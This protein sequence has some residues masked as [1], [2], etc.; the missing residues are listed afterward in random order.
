MR[1]KFYY[2]HSG[3]TYSPTSVLLFRPYLVSSHGGGGVIFNS[4]DCPCVRRSSS[5]IQSSL[6]YL[7]ISS[8]SIIPLEGH[9]PFRPCLRNYGCHFPFSPHLLKTQEG[10]HPFRPSSLPTGVIFLPSGAVTSMESKASLLPSSSAKLASVTSPS[11]SV[12]AITC[13]NQ[14][15]KTRN[16]QHSTARIKLCFSSGNTVTT[17]P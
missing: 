1:I 7:P 15:H 4:Q 2:I 3:R 13:Q 10:H 14:I 8:S 5:S 9:R 16:D 17:E 6:A 11:L 12:P